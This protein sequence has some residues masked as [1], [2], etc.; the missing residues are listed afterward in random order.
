[1]MQRLLIQKEFCV[2]TTLN[3]GAYP[4]TVD[5][6][7]TFDGQEFA[8]ET[9]N[10]SVEHLED[11]CYSVHGKTG[12][13]C[14][15]CVGFK[16]I[17]IAD[18]W[19]TVCPKAIIK[20]PGVRDS[21]IN[22]PCNEMGN[23]DMDDIDDIT[24]GLTAFGFDL[25]TSTTLTQDM[26]TLSAPFSVAN[27]LMVS[28]LA[29]A[30]ETRQQLHDALHLG[31]H[32]DH[33][34]VAESYGA[35]MG[36]LQHEDAEVTSYV[37][38]TLW[39]GSD[40]FDKVN[41]DFKHKSREFV[42][43]RKLDFSGGSEQ[44]TQA[45]NDNVSQG[46][47]GHIP[48]A[49]T[50]NVGTHTVMLFTNCVYLSASFETEFTHTNAMY[51]HDTTHKGGPWKN[52]K[53]EMMYTDKEQVFNVAWTKH[54][55]VIEVPLKGEF[56]DFV[57]YMIR[58][59]KFTELDTIK[60]EKE[61]QEND[62]EDV[63]NRMGETKMQLSFPIFEMFYALDLTQQLQDLG[64]TD[65]MDPKKSNMKPLFKNNTHLNAYDDA[66]TR[67]GWIKI[68]PT[69][70]EAAAFSGDGMG[71]EASQSGKIAHADKPFLFIIMD[72]G[73]NTMLFAGRVTN[74]NGWYLDDTMRPHHNIGAIVLIVLCLLLVAYCGVMGAYN[75]TYHGMSGSEAIPH[76]DCLV[77]C[78]L[79]SV[80]ACQTGYSMCLGLCLGRRDDLEE[81]G[82]QG[83]YAPMG[84]D[85]ADPLL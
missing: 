23:E 66:F 51:F 61:L 10:Q 74:P 59:R 13:G 49:I 35:L 25:L 3:Q 75:V 52:T 81:V 6:V 38:S 17:E 43:I 55:E 1:M 39:F 85:H 11:Q 20:C 5:V 24:Y 54:S 29:S 47:R 73:T 64:I 21:S 77:S 36:G 8:T 37:D 58:P 69:G 22:M 44:A 78:G 60:V 18:D 45:I 41:P 79:N 76:R 9:L 19:A 14:E 4:P 65:L 50:N 63:L 42:T 32:L 31:Q 40:Y 70:V 82:P 16:S 15:L 53:V 26:D 30:G 33:A 7:A 34:A 28:M 62:F 71:H 68:G 12:T 84:D 56:T 46:T 83:S 48:K 80:A 67:Q 2:H 27:T 57:M 72:R